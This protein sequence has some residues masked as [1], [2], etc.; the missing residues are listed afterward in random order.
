VRSA[1]PGSAGGAAAGSPRRSR[2]PLLL[3]ILAV[4]VVALLL[5]ACVFHE[6]TYERIARDVTVAIQH[7]DLAAV[8]KLQNAQTA[9]TVNHERVGRAADVLAPLGDV[10]GVKQ[11]AVNADTRVYDF[12]LTF[13]HGKAHERIQFDPERK[14]VHFGYDHVEKK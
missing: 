13:A 10:K 11:T 1:L 12:D 2:L 4:V 8:N 14:I 7:N 6:N 9:T 3:T 5:R